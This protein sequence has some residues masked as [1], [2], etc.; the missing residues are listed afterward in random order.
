M[1]KLLMTTK[2]FFPAILIL[3]VAALAVLSPAVAYAADRAFYV[4]ENPNSATYTQGATAAALRATF[5]Y[6]ASNSDR[7]NLDSDFPINVY[8]FLSSD[9]STADRSNMVGHSGVAYGRTI[10]HTTTV[11]P[12]TAT[13]GVFYYFAVIDYGEAV[14][15]NGSWATLNAYTTSAVARIEVVAPQTGNNN[16]GHNNDTPVG[17]T[18]GDTDTGQTD[19]DTVLDSTDAINFW[20]NLKSK[21]T[22]RN[23]S[24]SWALVNLLLAFFGTILAAVII[25][26]AVVTKKKVGVLWVVLTGIMAVLGVVLFVLTENMKNPMVLT[27]FWTIIHAVIAAVA[28]LFAVFSYIKKQQDKAATQKAEEKT[29]DNPRDEKENSTE[30]KEEEK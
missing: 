23:N 12:S 19:K 3:A 4:T 15:I 14:T 27:D 28:I 2:R 26:R 29:T 10:S 24:S 25:T 18:P 16:Q 11:T 21:F 22:T 30:T 8:W 17:E 20:E 1:K 6:N 5:Q 13:V 7:N 9:N